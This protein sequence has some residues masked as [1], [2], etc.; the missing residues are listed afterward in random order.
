MMQLQPLQ[1]DDRRCVV[2]FPLLPTGMPVPA[3]HEREYLRF[4]SQTVNTACG[5][6]STSP[7]IID[8]RSLVPP[9]LP[10]TPVWSV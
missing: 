8:E 7:T 9:G 2:D 1:S 5:R 3:Y 10:G 4:I 6:A